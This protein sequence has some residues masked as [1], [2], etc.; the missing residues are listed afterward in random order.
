MSRIEQIRANLAKRK[1]SFERDNSVFPFW[2]LAF[3]SSATLRL[4]PY[5]DQTTGNFW[6]EK[7]MV[8][9]MFVDPNDEGKTIYYKAPCREMYV[10]GNPQDLCPVLVPVRAL[11]KEAEELKNTG[12]DTESKRLIKI[13]GL[14]WK[15]FTFYYQGFVIKPG[16]TESEELPEN[17]I[18][19][20]PFVKQ[21][22]KIIE[23]SLDNKDDPFDFLPTGDF[24]EDDI[25][26][27]T[28]DNVDEAELERIVQKFEGHNFIVHK[29]KQGEYPNWATGTGWAR[30]S[31]AT[32]TED[33]ILALAEYG[34]HDLTVRLPER[35]SE[36]KY[37]VL[38]EMMDLSLDRLLNGG[39]GF[40]NKEWE[41]AGIKPMAG[42]KTE[43]SEESTSTSNTKTTTSSSKLKDRL[44][45]TT[46]GNGGGTNALD[47]I[48]KRGVKTE[49]P[50]EVT[51]A[52]STSEPAKAPPTDVKA[53]AAK[54]KGRIS[55]E[56]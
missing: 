38:R 44:K 20:F 56:A 15:K 47:N 1:G 16:F 45:K 29:T 3:N 17:P 27:L 11:Y 9:M 48:R 46:A 52:P 42:R 21:I 22:H 23:T 36:E 43:D 2:N 41:A 10:P 37:A 49:A 28:S 35:P 8:P 33:Q 18:R 34:Y 40:W 54:I 7:V 12:Q 51:D 55:Q 50:I 19:V 25:A 39:D 24:T 14:H 53:L 31:K 26:S 13:A 6:T 5:N 30:N 32:L 4:L